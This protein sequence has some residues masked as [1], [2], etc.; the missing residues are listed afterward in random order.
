MR[1][2]TAGAEERAEYSNMSATT[3]TS[4]VAAVRPEAQ[5][6]VRKQEGVLQYKDLLL[7]LIWRDIK[8]RYKQSIMGFFW[9]ILMPILIIGSGLIVMLAVST[10]SGRPINKLDV[11]SVAI[12]AV[13]WA[14][15]VAA[16]RFG[17][18]SL[19][20]NKELVTK[21]Y[22]PREILPIAAVFANLFDFAVAGGVLTVI[23]G[24]LRVG[25]NWQILWVPLLLVLLILLTVGCALF[26]ACANLF[27]R[28]VKYLVEVFLTYGIFFTPVFYSASKLGKWGPIVL[29]NPIGSILECLNNVIILGRP[30]QLPWLIYSAVWAFC[31]SLL[32]WRIFRRAESAFAESI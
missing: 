20:S 1:L 31:G 7:M 8:I 10:L 25:A 2:G 26:L 15:C 21:I 32:A 9:A 12:K 30:P 28:D 4:L 13:P 27:F 6:G 22:F 11:L 3:Q 16:I 19:V 29:L 23:L 18:N 24:I 14:F 17:T 5:S